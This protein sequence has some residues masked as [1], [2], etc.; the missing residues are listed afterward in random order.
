MDREHSELLGLYAD[1]W[2]AMSKDGVVATAETI[3]DLFC[4]ADE[5]Q[6]PRSDIV[7]D[8]LDTNPRSLIL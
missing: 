7:H 3:D 8:Y 4:K 5:L 2:V 1:R 6:I